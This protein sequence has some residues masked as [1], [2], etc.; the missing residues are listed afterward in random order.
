MGHV[1]TNEKRVLGGARGN[2]EKRGDLFL[3]EITPSGPH[4]HHF[5][6]TGKN[7]KRALLRPKKNGPT[8]SY[9]F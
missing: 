6:S 2:Q 3:P 9:S 1:L 8:S 7:A 4:L 5:K